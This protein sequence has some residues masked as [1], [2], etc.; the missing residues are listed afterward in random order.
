[1]SKD[2]AASVHARLLGHAHKVGDEFNLVL[3]R[4]A[5]ERFL[6]R[7][8]IS[9]VRDQFCLKG[10][11]LFQVWF[12]EPHRLGGHPKSGQ[13]WSPQNRPVEEARGGVHHA[14]WIAVFKS[15]RGRVR[16]LL[17]PHFKRWAWC[18]SRSSM[19]VTVA[20]SPRSFPQSSTGRFEV[21]TVLARS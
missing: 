10:A 2:M 9:E 1:M 11:Q 14:S 7:L 5:V 18:I 12:D 16:Q 13:L 20:V 17:G 15:F 19:A 6:Y 4:Y 8:S 3:T 21:S